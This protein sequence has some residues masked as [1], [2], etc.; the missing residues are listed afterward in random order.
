MCVKRAKKN[1][2]SVGIVARSCLRRNIR[3]DGTMAGPVTKD[4]M[5]CDFN[6]RKQH[7]AECHD[8]PIRIKY[9]AEVCKKKKTAHKTTHD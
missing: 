2:A 9:S 8:W 7:A 4:S 6:D 3:D 1:V 5:V